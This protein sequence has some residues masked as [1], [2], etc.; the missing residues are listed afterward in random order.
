MRHE[1]ESRVASFGLG[2]R[3]GGWSCVCR[4][5]TRRGAWISG[6]SRGS[7]TDRRGGAVG[8]GSVH[9][10]CNG[11][12][13]GPDP[14]IRRTQCRSGPDPAGYPC[15][16]D[17]AVSDRNVTGG[18]VCSGIAH[19]RR[20]GNAGRSRRR[21]PAKPGN[22][23]NEVSRSPDSSLPVAAGLSGFISGAPLRPRYPR[24]PFL[25]QT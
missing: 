5:S 12:P 13:R 10:G 14:G 17:H 7:E 24:P 2:C 11:D 9:A 3:S 23:G 22:R 21:Y 25:S 6:D 4:G 20:A 1:D 16:A 15:F 18:A 19:K 8:E